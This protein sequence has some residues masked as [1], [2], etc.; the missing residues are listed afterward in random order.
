MSKQDDS[1]DNLLYGNVFKTMLSLS[2]PA[3]LG[4][5]VI[6]LSYY[7]QPYEGGK[8][9]SGSSLCDYHS[10]VY[11]GSYNPLVFYKEE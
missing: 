11:S 7:D 1:S 5:V 6:G 2:V 9:N 3:I 10:P 4:M 8:W